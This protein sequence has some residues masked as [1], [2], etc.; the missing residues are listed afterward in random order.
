MAAFV[1]NLF[2]F[3]T[4][5]FSGLLVLIS[6]YWISAI[7]GM[8]DI[9][10]L[11]GD[12]EIDAEADPAGL[13]GWLHKFKLDGIPLTITLS[14]VTLAAWFISFLAVHFIYP[15]LPPNW[16]QLSVGLWILVLAPVIAALIVSPLLQPLK[17]LFKKLPE[18]N[19][20]SLLGKRVQIRSHKV[21]SSFGEAL[22]ADGGAGLILKVRATEP[23]TLVRGQTAVL[24]SYD[25]TTNT[26]QVI[27]A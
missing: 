18:K 17:P 1:N 21:T 8:V 22:L 6:L 5:C 15:H 12:L 25:T 11:D 26:Y 4:I 10:I 23:N 19:A 20:T 2:T 16:I 3:P 7:L 14:F 13:T 27:P 9:E 24:H